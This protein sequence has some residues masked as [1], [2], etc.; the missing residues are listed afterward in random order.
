MKNESKDKKTQDL[1]KQAR[2]GS[3]EAFAQLYDLHAKGIYKHILF[4][5]R[6]PKMAE[7]I[8]SQVF[9]KIWEA[10]RKG[11]AIHSFRAFAMRSAQNLF[12]DQTRK[13]EYQNTSLEKLT[14][15]GFEPRGELS[16][17]REAEASEATKALQGALE[18]INAEQRQILTLR[19]LDELTIPEIAEITGKKPGTIYVLIHRGVRALKLILKGSS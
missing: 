17:S 18:Q 14:E 12:I 19:Y 13:K 8:T 16:T 11:V 1:L 7:D 15:A 6:D 2:Q 4:R 9:I 10:L 3:Q 5:S